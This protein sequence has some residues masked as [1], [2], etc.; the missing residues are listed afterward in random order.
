[1]KINKTQTN[2]KGFTL[3]ELMI[4]VAIIGIL[5]AV[6]VPQYQTYTQRSTATAES[7]AAMRPIQLGISEFAA[8]NAALPTTDQYDDIMDPITAIGGGTASGQILTVTWDATV[9]TVTF[10]S[11]ANN[12]SIPSGLSEGTIII[13]PAI[14][15]AGAVSFAVTGG[16]IDANLRPKL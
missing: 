9:M 12:S 15:A 4:V 13:T 10:D 7:I 14:N 2:Q 11:T 6:A 16:S 1:M 3:I 5:A 8:I